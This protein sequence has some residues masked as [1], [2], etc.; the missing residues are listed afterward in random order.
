MFPGG[1]F[2]AELAALADP[3]LLPQTVAAAVGMRDVSVRPADR[4]VDFLSDKHLLLVLDN[5]EHLVDACATL[6]RRLLVA[7][8][9]LRVLATSRQRLGVEGEH[10]LAVEP[11]SVPSEDDDELRSSAFESVSLFCDRAAAVSP[12]FAMSDDNLPLIATIC[13][14]LDGLP[15]GIE[16]AAVWLRVL[17]IGELHDRLDDKFG[18]LTGAMRTAPA[19]QRGLDTVIDWSYQLCSP[20]ERMAWA[21]L[22]VF[23][24]GFDLS[25]A[26]FVCTGDGI[27]RGQ[28]LML[29][30]GLVD[31]SILVREGDP[32]G[33]AARYRMLG[34]LVEFGAARLAEAGMSAVV[35]ERHREYFGRLGSEYAEHEF[36]ADQTEWV[37]RLQRDHANIRR[38]LDS[39][40][41]D[42]EPLSAMDLAADLFTYWIA[43]GHL[44]EGFGWLDRALA[45][46]TGSV[47][48]RAR[49][50]H[51]R[52][53]LCTWL[54]VRESLTARLEEYRVLVTTLDDPSLVARFQ[55]CEGAAT[56][57]LG[58]PAR[59]CAILE[60][61]LPSCRAVADDALAAQALT[62]L[63]VPRF[64]LARVD[65]EDAG[66]EALDL[67]DAHGRPPW[68]TSFALWVVGMAVWR[69][70]DIPRAEKLHCEAISLCR[71]MN[72]HSGIALSLEALAWCAASAQ[73]FV[74]AVRLLGAAKMLWRQSGAERIE[75]AL[76]EVSEKECAELARAALG[77]GGFQ[78]AFAWG[79]SLDLDHAVAFALAERPAR[80]NK[81]RRGDSSSELTRRESEIASLVADGLTN[82]EIAERLVI[83]QRTADTHVEHIL[84]KLGFTSRAQIA[85]WLTARDAIG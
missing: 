59:A 79:E 46:D 29:M 12:R 47:P 11:L 48:S 43:G 17:S 49:A 16:L 78:D 15:L 41:G 7:A 21:R 14:S 3:A 74:R 23:R 58:D 68:H 63:A 51:A 19:R 26:E 24:G 52:V 8:P 69:R 70:G 35:S 1:V 33:C 20:Y 22:S 57:F 42:G 55:M 50:L 76:R 85:A 83:S 18:L 40:L 36:G 5:C 72:D 13:R 77:P 65:A 67:C 44:A 66:Q 45:F 82:K 10:L 27:E 53:L 54:G 2:V 62:Y 25:A 6:V 84:R 37:L 28:V 38:A 71:P 80:A 32:S 30:A 73:Q 9:K 61:A 64:I 81:R 4:L 31:K 34:T 60:R 56:Y 75:S 39:W